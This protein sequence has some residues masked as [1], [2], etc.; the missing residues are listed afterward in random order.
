MFEIDDIL[1]SGDGFSDLLD[2]GLLEHLYFVGLGNELLDDGVGSNVFLLVLLYLGFRR[3]FLNVVEDIHARGFQSKGVGLLGNRLASL[4]QSLILEDVLFLNEVVFEGSPLKE[5]LLL[6][7][8]LA[9]YLQE[10]VVQFLLEKPL[11]HDPH[12]R[13]IHSRHCFEGKRGLFK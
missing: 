11:L 6:L 10:L 12:F 7:Q 4:E 2:I 1:K 13:R 8:L 5:E 9:D 3:H